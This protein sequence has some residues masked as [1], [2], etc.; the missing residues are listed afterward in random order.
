LNV[1]G[2]NTANENDRSLVAV[3]RFGQSD[4]EIGGDL[5][6]FDTPSYKDIEASIAPKVGRVEVYNVHHNNSHSSNPEWFQITEP[7]V[8]IFSCKCP[9]VL[10]VTPH[11]TRW[12]CP[13]GVKC[14]W[15][16]AGEVQVRL[17]TMDFAVIY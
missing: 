17:P 15:T 9:Q 6:G 5:S 4:A 11:R 14:Y 12:K 2:V 10:M 7:K 8:G 16:S 13:R 1:N 3:V